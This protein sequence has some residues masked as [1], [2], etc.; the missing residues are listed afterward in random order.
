MKPKIGIVANERFFLTDKIDFWMSYTSKGDVEGIRDAGGLAFII[1][2]DDASHTKEYI[3]TIDRLILAGGQDVA[4][5][6]YQ[7]GTSPLLGETSEARDRFEIALIHEA[8]KQRKP[9]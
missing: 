4:A 7:Q 3:D 5:H 9:I 6:S 2:I 8:M 1:S